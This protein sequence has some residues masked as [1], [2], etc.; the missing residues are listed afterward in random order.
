MYKG[1]GPD[2]PTEVKRD[3]TGSGLTRAKGEFARYF[4]E[5]SQEKNLGGMI[6]K[7]AEGGE[8]GDTVPAMLTPGEFVLNNHFS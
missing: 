7:F 6:Q 1:I 5:M 2:W 8:A 3:V 4:K